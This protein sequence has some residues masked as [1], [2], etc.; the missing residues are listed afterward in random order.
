MRFRL[1]HFRW[2]TAIFFAILA[3]G[4]KTITSVKRE[5]CSMSVQARIATLEAKRKQL[6]QFIN[7]YYNH[8]L[9]DVEVA[10]MKKKRLRIEDQISKLL[11]RNS[12][13]AG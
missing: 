5:A 7:E 9:S 1:G 12:A 13:T 10:R 6:S 8:H 2:K 4:K 3:F 11:R